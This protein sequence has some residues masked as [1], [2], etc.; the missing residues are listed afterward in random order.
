MTENHEDM[1]DT[2]KVV[3]KLMKDTERAILRVAIQQDCQSP[4]W[5][6]N[7]MRKFALAVRNGETVEPGTASFCI[8]LLAAAING[9]QVACPTCH[10]QMNAPKCLPQH[11]R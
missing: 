9:P 5:V 7:V 10:G 6:A 2:P 4:F 1:D 3:N 8:G 11:R